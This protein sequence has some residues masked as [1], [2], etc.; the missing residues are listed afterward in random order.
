MTKAVSLADVA[1]VAVDDLRKGREAAIDGALAR[2]LAAAIE[3]ALLTAVRGE[4][5]A[6]AADCTRRAELWERTLEAPATSE[7]LRQEAEHR[8]NEARYLADL[9]ATRA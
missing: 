7:P 3:L 4:R 1:R 8:A 2:E 5:R 6:C 9:I